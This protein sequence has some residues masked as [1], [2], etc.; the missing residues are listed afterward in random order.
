MCKITLII[1]YI[2]ITL[3]ILYTSGSLYLRFIRHTLSFDLR[4][5]GSVSGTSRISI[6][7]F[8]GPDKLG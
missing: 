7:L 4:S 8:S 1:L 5:M 2:L 3:I 6:S